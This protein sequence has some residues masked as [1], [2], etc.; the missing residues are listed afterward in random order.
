MSVA[1]YFILIISI[2]FILVSMVF[3]D[4]LLLSAILFVAG[5]IG[6]LYLIKRFNA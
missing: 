2:V 5:V 3:G 4:L 6:L 1:R